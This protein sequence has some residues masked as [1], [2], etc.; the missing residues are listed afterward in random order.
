M[1]LR[2]A[3]MVKRLASSVPSAS[4]KRDQTAHVH[5]SQVLL[6]LIRLPDCTASTSLQLFVLSMETPKLGPTSLPFVSIMDSARVLPPK[7]IQATLDALAR[8][9]GWGTY[10]SKLNG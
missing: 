9:N 10:K 5:V 8:M 2:C 1:Q 3:G 6:P 7:R 4:T